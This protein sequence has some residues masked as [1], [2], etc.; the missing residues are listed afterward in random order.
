VADIVSTLLSSV[1]WPFP[2]RPSLENL[3]DPEARRL[4]ATAFT[5]LGFAVLLLTIGSVV[6]RMRLV[7]F[8]AALPL[9]FIQGPSLALLLVDAT[10][11]SYRPSP[12]GFTAA[13]IAEGRRVFA[14]SCVGCHGQFGDG[15]G[16]VGQAADLRLP[17]IWSHPAGDL[18]WFLSHGIEAQD[19]MPAMPAFE[20][21][22]PEHARWSAIDYIHALNTGA[23]TRGLNGWPD[24]VLAPGISLTCTTIAAHG[25]ADLRGKAVRILLGMLPVP[26]DSVPPVDGIAVVTVWIPGEATETAPAPGVDCMAQGNTDD[27]AA[28]A[29]LA[30]SAD[31]HV[32]TA[33]FLI[34]PEGVLRSVWRKGDGDAWSDPDRLLEEVRAICTQPWTIETGDEHEHH[35]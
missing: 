9:F 13:S 6:R 34:D 8:L 32:T 16:G 29:I 22:L 27:V 21:I 10:P 30:G 5:Q 14:G 28:Y 31:G 25:L 19:D 4:I 11:T 15:V 23:V 2:V 20:S 12:T 24:R 33:R 35:R 26:L 1:S 17:H 7:A 3:A 18:F